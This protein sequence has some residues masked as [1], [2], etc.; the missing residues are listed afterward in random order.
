MAYL[1]LRVKV[2]GVEEGA[3]QGRGLNHLD[4]LGGK[5]GFNSVIL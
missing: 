5:G 1:E 3:R 2:R 4:P